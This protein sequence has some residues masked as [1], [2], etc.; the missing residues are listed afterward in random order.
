MAC[1]GALSRKQAHRRK[2][3]SGIVVTGWPTTI[4]RSVGTF[5]LAARAGSAGGQSSRRSRPQWALYGPIKPAHAGR[6][7]GAAGACSV[8]APATTGQMAHRSSGLKRQGRHLLRS[9]QE[10]H[11]GFK[12]F[13]QGD[14]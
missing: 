12:S 5:S 13:D 3:S 8:D 1:S 14:L 7:E 10:A 2:P 9:T 6:S 4:V 11:R